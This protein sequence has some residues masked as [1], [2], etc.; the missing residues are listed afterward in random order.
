[1]RPISAES[2]DGERWREM[3]RGRDGRDERWLGEEMTVAYRSSTAT[4]GT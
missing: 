3:A 4:T 1:M 2:G